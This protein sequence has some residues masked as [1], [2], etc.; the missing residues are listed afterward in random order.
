VSGINWRKK[1]NDIIEPWGFTLVKTEEIK[2]IMGLI[3]AYD[4]FAREQ[5]EQHQDLFVDREAGSIKAVTL[6]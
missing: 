2:Q 5:L 6:H 4:T 1:L 3:C